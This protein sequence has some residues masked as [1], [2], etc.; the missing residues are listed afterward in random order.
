MRP[1]ASDIIKTYP[2]RGPMQQF[3]LVELTAFHC[4]RCGQSK[5]SKLLVVYADNWN[6]LLCN[7]CYGRLLSIYQIRSGTKS[8][9][10]KA[11]ELANVL[12]TLHSKDQINEAE[13]RYRLAETRAEILSRHAMR[14]IAT[15]EFL[16]QA[17]ESA[18]DL[19]W[20]PAMIGLCKAVEIEVLH[21]IL[22]PLA[23]QLRGVSLDADKNDKDLGRVARFLSHPDLPPPE[24]GTFSYFLQTSLNSETRRST[25][26]SI[27]GLHRLFS[28]WPNAS[29]LTDIRGC[30]D[31]LISL[32]RNFRNRAAHLE[33]LSHRDYQACREFVIG[34]DGLLWKLIFAT[35]RQKK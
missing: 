5:K 2:S 19:D 1:L 13:R 10:E 16:S 18:S 25:S 7:A 12:L 15:A 27:K 32:T 6:R 34:R 26:P 20:S 33:L 8:D 29:W 14:F 28:L 9:D 35:Q 30:Y 22:H 4:F 11:A 23:A 3:R 21:R 17:L 24:L 31:S